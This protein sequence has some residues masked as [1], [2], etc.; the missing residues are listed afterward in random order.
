MA[1]DWA[2]AW[3]SLPSIRAR[4]DGPAI[5]T[6]GRQWH[7]Q[8][9]CRA[10][11]ATCVVRGLLLRAS[12]GI[13]GPSPSYCG[14][15]PSD[16][17]CEMSC[18]KKHD[19]CLCRATV[20]GLA[21]HHPAYH[22]KWCAVFVRTGWPRLDLVIVA[23]SPWLSCLHAMSSRVAARHTQ[24][25][26]PEMTVPGKHRGPTQF[27]GRGL[28]HS[29]PENRYTTRPSARKCTGRLRYAMRTTPLPRRHYCGRHASGRR[30]RCS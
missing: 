6:C 12:N 28:C 21:A 20:A 10:V 27:S 30:L 1:V 22:A 18:T 17:S 29:P 13:R 14:T 25:A 23:S 26:A 2:G 4:R 9:H 15:L 16:A 3:P 24:R 7:P 19:S 8:Q 11:V 5:C